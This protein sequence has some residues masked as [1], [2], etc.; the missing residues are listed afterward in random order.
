MIMNKSILNSD[1]YCGD[2]AKT[3]KNLDIH[4]LKGTRILIT[5]ATGLIC[6]AVV[7]VLLWCN[8]HLNSGISIYAAVRSSEKLERRFP[9]GQAN[10][11]IPVHYDATKAQNFSFSVDYIIHGASNASPDKYLSEPV[12]TMMANIA[13][14]HNLL[15]YARNCSLK[16]F[17]YI[18]SSEVYGKCLPGRPLKESD[19]GTTDILS[20]RASYPVGK[21]AA[22][23]LCVAFSN[24]YGVDISIVRPGHV[25]GPTASEQDH[26]V[27]SAFAWR[28]A[29]GEDLIMKSA[30]TQIRSYCHC[31]DCAGA[32]LTV[33]TCGKNKEAYNISNQESIITIRQMAEIIAKNSGVRLIVDVPTQSELQAFN[34]MDNS[35]L[36]SEKLYALGWTGLFDPDTGFANT[37]TALRE[38]YFPQKGAYPPCS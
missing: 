3:A 23:A 17:V 32:V 22:E 25:Y 15:S 27:S 34:P 1:T 9:D 7:D 10:G 11:L 14:V 16:K 35:S 26:R 21:Q 4:A 29:G 37:I 12:D 31:L 13:G 38:V 33:L 6:S 24:Q 8:T 28:A 20:P 18:S 5:G 2:I 36:D 30:G 19:C